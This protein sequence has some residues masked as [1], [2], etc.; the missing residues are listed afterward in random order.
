MKTQKNKKFKVRKFPFLIF[1]FF[2]FLPFF[3]SAEEK[4]ELNTASVEQLEKIIG[5]GPVLAQRIINARPFCSLDDLVKVKGIGEKTLQKIKNQGLATVNYSNCSNYPNQT[6]NQDGQTIN[7]Q[8]AEEKSINPVSPTNQSVQNISTNPT[9]NINYPQ[10]IIFNEI[11]PNPEGADEK[12]EWI[13]I[14]NQNNF[15]INLEAWQIKDKKG[16]TTNYT[17]SQGKK[18]AGLAYLLLKRCESKITLNN[19]GD[20]LELLNPKGE[21]VDF[22]SFEKA[23]LNRSYNKTPSGWVWSSSL[24]PLSKNIISNN[25]NNNTANE[26][27]SEEKKSKSSFVQEGNKNNIQLEKE[28]AIIGE[29][30]PKSSN[31]FYVFFCAL[32]LA[33][34]SGAIVLIIKRKILKNPQS[35]KGIDKN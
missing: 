8:V 3:I 20:A 26:K 27:E 7:P 1:I 10:G 25:D 2:I 30:I 34:L 31:F 32:G 23:P 6:S 16:K 15:E 12:N 24:T 11:L 18:I 22:V 21:I 13:E 5:I 33:C 29:K 35:I 28:T 14:F 4:I 17:F 19:E 9:S